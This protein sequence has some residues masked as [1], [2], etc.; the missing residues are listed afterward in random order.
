MEKGEGRAHQRRRKA[1]ENARKENKKSPHK[2]NPQSKRSSKKEGDIMRAEVRRYKEAEKVQHFI[3]ESESRRGNCFVQYQN[4]SIG[5]NEETKARAEANL[6]RI[7]ALASHQQSFHHV[8]DPLPA[9]HE[10]PHHSINTANATT[11]SPCRFFLPRKSHGKSSTESDENHPKKQQADSKSN[12]IISS[13]DKEKSRPLTKKASSH[14]TSNEKKVDSSPS[15]DHVGEPSKSR[16]Y[17]VC[18]TR[19]TEQNTKTC[20]SKSKLKNKSNKPGTSPTLQARKS[21]SGLPS[22]EGVISP[23]SDLHKQVIA[24]KSKMNHPTVELD[25]FASTAAAVKATLTSKSTLFE[26]QMEDMLRETLHILAQAHKESK[27]VSSTGSIDVITNTCNTGLDRDDKRQDQCKE[28][29]D[30]NIFE[31]PSSLDYLRHMEDRKEVKSTVNTTICPGTTI[32]SPKAL[33]LRYEDKLHKAVN[34]RGLTKSPG[35][36][37]KS[38]CKQLTVP[39]SNPSFQPWPQYHEGQVQH[40]FEHNQVNSKISFESESDWS[41]G[42]HHHYYPGHYQH[43]GPHYSSSYSCCSG[44]KPPRRARISYS[45]NEGNPDHHSIHQTYKT[46]PHHSESVGGGDGGTIDW[47]ERNTMGDFSFLRALNQHQV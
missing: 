27:C 38:H 43:Q 46:Y 40:P 13:S 22:R 42:Q 2:P 4:D 11:V 7:L 1:A 12:I 45:Y 17:E 9:S 19:N 29:N 5:M 39:K 35:R 30:N 16:N 44:G 18:D 14:K 26:I 33:L 15:C 24:A 36:S 20:S 10:V 37:G 34:S 6:T 41:T 28:K 3:P 31:T 21:T 47:V 25:S 23:N 8:S 32:I